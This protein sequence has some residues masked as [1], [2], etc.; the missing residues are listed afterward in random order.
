M[1]VT[2]KCQYAHEQEK[3]G[4]FRN[5]F[6]DLKKQETLQVNKPKSSP[7]SSS[8]SSRNVFS[9]YDKATTPGTSSPSSSST[10]KPT[11]PSPLLSKKW[12]PLDDGITVS[13]P[14]SIDDPP[15][16]AE[17]RSYISNVLYGPT[18]RKR[19]PVFCDICPV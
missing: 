9:P 12:S 15:T 10:S 5:R 4:S 18:T 1:D 16:K 11:N 3:L 8:A 13:L 17:V 14:G 2:C 7:S 19:L 6:R